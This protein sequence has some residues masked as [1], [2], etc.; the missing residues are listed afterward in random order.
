MDLG[1]EEVNG[2]DVDMQDAVYSIVSKGQF[3]CTRWVKKQYER[4]FSI[5]RGSI[6]I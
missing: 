6:E 5:I 2:A 3:M 1:R 4:D